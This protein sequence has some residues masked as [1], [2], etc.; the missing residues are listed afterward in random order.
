MIESA[1][2]QVMVHQIQTADDKTK[3]ELMDRKLVC[4]WSLSCH[5][6]STLTVAVLVICQRDAAPS[7]FESLAKKRE[8]EKHERDRAFKKSYF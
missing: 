6:F 5:T 4:V 2:V 7:T 8:M 3:K 1:R